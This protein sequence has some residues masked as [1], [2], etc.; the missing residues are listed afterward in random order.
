MQIK[1]KNPNKGQIVASRSHL[2]D[3]TKAFVEQQK[4]QFKEIELVPAGSSLKFCL[5]AEGKA[6]IY[7]RLAPTMEW[8]TA[9]GQI[10]AEEAGA[11]V[12]IAD[13]GKPV[14]YNKEDLLNPYFIVRPKQV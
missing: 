12:V 11:E 5:V 6:D 8:D 10:V 14:Q 2:N 4:K 1:V 3:A 7:P 13:T 9:A